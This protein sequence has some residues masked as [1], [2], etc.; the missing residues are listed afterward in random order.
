MAGK[1]RKTVFV[2]QDCGAESAKWMG[3]CPGCG[4]WNTL[5]EEIVIFARPAEAESA[6]IIDLIADSS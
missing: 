3:K 2:C 6:P 4:A 1:K 5:V